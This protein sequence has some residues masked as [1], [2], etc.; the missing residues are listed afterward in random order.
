MFQQVGKAFQ[1]AC[2]FGGGG[3]C[4]LGLRGKGGING[5]GGS[6]RVGKGYAADGVAVVGGV[7]H[8]L[9]FA[10]GYG[11]AVNQRCGGVALRAGGFQAAF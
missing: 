10:I 7:A 1:A 9:R 5:G 4:P 3:G 11:L 2:A 8:G 6:L